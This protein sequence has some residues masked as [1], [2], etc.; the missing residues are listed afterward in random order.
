MTTKKAFISYSWDDDAHKEW[1]LN[2]A[3]TLIENGIDVILDQYD[4]SA[5]KEMTHFMETAMTADKVL[6]VMTPNYKIKADKRQGGVGY[7]Y[8][9]LTKELY[10]GEPD[11]ERII[12]IL[13]GGDSKESSPMFLA[14]RIF[15]DMR[16]Q[17]LFDAKFFELV[18][19]ITDRPLVIKPK[20]GVLPD[21]DKSTIPE[22]DKAILD[23][24]KK[25]EFIRKK[26]SILESTE[27]VRIFTEK[28]EEIV[29]QISESLD[30]YKKNFGIHF[31]IKK[32]NYYPSLTFTTV[33]FTSHFASEARTQNDASD[34]YVKLNLYKGPAGFGELG[35]DYR[36][37]IVEM[38]S[39]KYVFDLDENFNP[40]FVKSDA[41]LIRL[42][43]HDI[44]TA[45]VRDVIANEIKLRTS[46]L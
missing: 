5:G 18:K 20:L 21:F 16:D 46:K 19:L 35:F 37:N 34:A 17:R 32:D 14:T 3:N 23:F 8:S 25:E 7:E 43:A 39:H 15:H 38:Y 40:I 2:L 42:V 41:P 31:Y 28:S 22:I 30:N 36:E 29:K 4:L 33:N 44:A 27:G 10:D 1:V 13:K 9:M 11:K 26:K 24:K 45:A 12:P 6:V